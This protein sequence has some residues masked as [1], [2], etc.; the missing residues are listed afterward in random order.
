MIY[1][2]MITEGMLKQSKVGTDTRKVKVK[3]IYVLIYMCVSQL[4]IDH[5][6]IFHWK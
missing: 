6:I 2:Y 1:V 5:T 3:M 4:Q